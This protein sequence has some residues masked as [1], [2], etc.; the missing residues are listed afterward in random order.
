MGHLNNAK[1]F[2][3][4]EQ[5]RIEYVRQVCEWGGDWRKLGMILAKTTME[6]KKPVVYGDAITVFTRCSRMGGKS[7]DLDYVIARGESEDIVAMSTTVMVAFDYE[8]Q[9]TI[10]V[11]ELWR[12]RILAYE[13]AAPA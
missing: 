10:P 3:Y 11:P 13:P 6:F 7:F 12:E 4:I 8:T 5:A 9:Q 1:Y 2:T